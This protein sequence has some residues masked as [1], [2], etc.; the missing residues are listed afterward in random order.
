MAVSA[1]KSFGESLARHGQLD[2]ATATHAV[3]DDGSGRRR[4]VRRG[5]RAV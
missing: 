3:E 4:L 2:G 1:A 5:F